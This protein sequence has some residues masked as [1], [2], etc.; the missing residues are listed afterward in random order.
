L[1]LIHSSLPSPS[2]PSLPSLPS[3][4][5]IIV[6]SYVFISLPVEGS[7]NFSQPVEQNYDDDEEFEFN[8]PEGF[9]VPDG[10]CPV[11][12]YKFSITCGGVTTVLTFQHDAFANPRM[13]RDMANGVPNMISFSNG[14]PEST[15]NSTGD[16][17]SFHYSTDTHDCSS[18]WIDVRLP[19]ALCK[20]AFEKVATDLE[21]L[22]K[23]WIALLAL[24]AITEQ[25]QE[26]E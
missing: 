8:P 23:K 20:N 18:A 12:A 16:M 1:H 9:S 17:V 24:H 25:E 26:E 13:W 2:L 10:H 7:P 5:A 3:E 6:D 21:C 4:Y 14:D 11:E 15:I 22:N 19:L